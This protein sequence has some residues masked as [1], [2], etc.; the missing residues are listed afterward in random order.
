MFSSHA[1]VA[2]V[3]AVEEVRGTK[4]SIPNILQVPSPRRNFDS[5]PAEG[6]GTSP[7]TPPASQVA[8][9]N[10]TVNASSSAATAFVTSRISRKV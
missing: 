7:L 1:L 9:V 8:P 2:T 3:N 5:S 6:A 10:V 4:E